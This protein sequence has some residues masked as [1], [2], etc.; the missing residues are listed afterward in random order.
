MI[1]EQIRPILLAG[2]A[3]KTKQ[4]VIRQTIQLFL[5]CILGLSIPLLA[6][7]DEL[8]FRHLSIK[9]GLSQNSGYAVVQDDKG[10]IWIGT[11]TGLVRCSSNACG[12][13]GK[14]SMRP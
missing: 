13:S 5:L 2:R 6:L 10:F 11:E 8:R 7:E 9:E 4:G 3:R 1:I 12:A 14:G